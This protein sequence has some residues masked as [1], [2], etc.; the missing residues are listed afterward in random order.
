MAALS[1]HHFK[2][3]VAHLV[4][5]SDV[6]IPVL[7]PAPELD[8]GQVLQFHN[9]NSNSNSVQTRSGSIGGSDSNAE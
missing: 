7:D 1:E 2:I 5:I 9:S 8:L 6:I 3:Y 4:C